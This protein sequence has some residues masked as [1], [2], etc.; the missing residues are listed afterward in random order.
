V[1]AVSDG[2]RVVIGAVM[3][4]IEDAG[5]H[6]GD[7]ACVLPPYILTER[8]QATMREQTVALAR[9]LGVVGLINVQYAMRDGRCTCSRSTRAPAARF[10]F[11]SKAVG[12]PLASVAARV[13][14][15]ETLEEIGY[16]KEIVPPYVSVKE[17]V[18]PVQQVPRV[19][20]GAR[21][22]DALDGRGDGDRGLVRGRVPQVA[23]GG[24][25]LAAPRGRDLRHVNDR[26]K[27]TAAPIVRR[28]YEMGFRLF[29]TEGTARFLQQRGVPCERVFKLHEG[30]PHGID[31][32]VNGEIQLLINTPMG[33]DAQVDDYRLR[34]AAIARRLAYTTTLS[35]AN[36]ACDAILS[37]RSRPG[38][39][40]SLQEWHAGLSAGVAA[41]VPPARRRHR[42]DPRRTRDAPMIDPTAFV[43]P[44]A[45]STRARASAPTPRS[46]T[47]ATCCPARWWARA[48]RS[49]RTWW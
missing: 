11:V 46:G 30:R 20:P 43:H 3:Q 42:S 23:A 47:S 44:R 27:P 45:S 49:G 17:A 19:R 33:K 25:Q 12:V 28:F 32:I 16:L 29:A 8:D 37:M 36:A 18:F 14:L 40:R 41:A 1:D 6:S 5:I 31:L 38:Q 2:E 4:H 15:G 7:S 24:R 9:R 22:R 26:D 13:M 48:A 39:V 21:P 34:Q 35:A 10:P